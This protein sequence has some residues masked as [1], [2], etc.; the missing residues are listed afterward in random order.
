MLNGL[1]LFTGIGGLTLALNEWVRPVAYCE[2]DRYA[3]SVLLSRIA[4]G[5]LP[6]AP[7]WDD[8]TS[9]GGTMLPDIDIIYGG[10][11][12]QDISSCG[13]R[14]G[15]EGER[16][17][18]F[19]ELVRLV[20]KINPRLVFLEN[21]PAIRTRG[22]FRVIERLT[23]LGYDCRWTNISAQEV[24]APHIRKRWFLLAH[25]NNKNRHQLTSVPKKNEKEK[26]SKVSRQN[27]TDE[28]I[29]ATWWK[30][31]PNIFRVANG[32]PYQLDRHRA[33]GSSVVPQQA[34]EAFMRLMGLN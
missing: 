31:E 7:I 23:S 3:R 14:E 29:N 5:K 34:R 21:V 6:R 24:G 10:F 22:L 2:I 12:C 25:A 20:K 8:I 27:K 13:N 26:M 4:D 1:D 33:L 16:S 30:T 19:F 32:L 9:L 11:P 18:L 28:P 17:G 15:L